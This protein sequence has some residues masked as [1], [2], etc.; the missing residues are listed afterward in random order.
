MEFD[1]LK[2]VWDSQ[3]NEL[4]WSI[5]ERALHNRI[6]SKKKQANHIT[7]VSE[8]LLIIVNMGAGY[9]VFQMNLSGHSGNIFMYLLAAWMLGISW[10][11]LFSRISRL[12]KNKQFDRSMQGDLNYAIS[13]ATYQVRLS[14][15]GRWSIVPIGLFTLLALWQSGK[16]VWIIVALLLFFA[17]TT[18]A[19]RWE[20]GIYKTRKRELEILKG[21]LESEG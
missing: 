11:L 21:K 17:L 19:S 8:L 10:Y 16:S 6:L 15:L 12:K 5:N 18:Y 4:I 1:E 3:N 7:N 14:L 2:Q 9:F 20:H 13:L